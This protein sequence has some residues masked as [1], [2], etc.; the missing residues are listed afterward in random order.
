MK[1]RLPG[2]PGEFESVEHGPYIYTNYYPDLYMQLTVDGVIEILEPSQ[3]PEDVY[4]PSEQ[5]DTER[6]REMDEQQSKQS[7]INGLKS[8]LEQSTQANATL[9][10]SL[11]GKSKEAE[12]LATKVRE[13]EQSNT[14]LQS[15][16]NMYRGLPADEK[17][18]TVMQDLRARAE[19][20]AQEVIRLSQT[21]STRVETAE[22]LAARALGLESDCKAHEKTIATLNE[23]IEVL[24]TGIK[25]VREDNG[26]LRNRLQVSE[27][28]APRLIRRIED[29]LSEFK[30][31]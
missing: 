6:I 4:T 16:L 26:A 31:A 22:Q 27:D 28:Q 9:S 18:N 19:T 7:V 3:L 23:Q 20:L 14:A 30:Q 13:L 10:D 29:L 24:K 25:A 12:D 21:R 8:K 11:M 5:L 15:E 2:I 1:Y 17:E